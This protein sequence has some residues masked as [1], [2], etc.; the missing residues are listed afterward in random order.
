MASRFTSSTP[1]VRFG[2]LV[3]NAN[4]VERN[5]VS[6]GIERAVGLEHLQPENLHI[7]HWSSAARNVHQQRR[8]S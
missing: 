4:L 7:R 5:P 1:R 2:D 6:V 8:F 3:R